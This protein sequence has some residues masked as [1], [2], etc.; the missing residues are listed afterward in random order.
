MFP[1]RQVVL[2]VHRT[3]DEAPQTGEAW[4][5]I[6]KDFDRVI[7]PGCVSHLALHSPLAHADLQNTC[8]QHHA[9]AAPEL[10]RL[11]PGKRTPLL[12]RSCPSLRAAYSRLRLAQTTYECILAD[13]YAGAVSNP[14]YARSAAVP[15]A[16][17]AL[18][19]TRA[20]VQLALLA[21]VHRAR[22]QGD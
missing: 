4:E 16:E 14:G 2:N 20:Q 3:A 9:L 19:A 6:S 21:R 1:V 22:V 12:R 5:D 18:T 13:M 10:L 7:L 15:R 11:L 17:L 8:L